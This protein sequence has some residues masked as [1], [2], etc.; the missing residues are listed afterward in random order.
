SSGERR[1]DESGSDGR[2]LGRSGSGGRGYG[3]SSERGRQIRRTVPQRFRWARLP[4]PAGIWSAPPAPTGPRLS[5]P[6]G[7]A[8]SSGDAATTRRPSLRCQCRSSPP[9][10]PELRLSHSR[11]PH[12]CRFHAHCCHRRRRHP[13]VEDSKA[14]AATT[15]V[16]AGAAPPS[17]W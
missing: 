4:D 11:T 10:M 16:R 15:M 7:R 9:V 5:T 1:L 13:K 3:G 8:S 17:T 2:D 6:K 12:N 14:A